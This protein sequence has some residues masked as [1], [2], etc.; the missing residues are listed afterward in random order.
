MK[1]GEQGSVRKRVGMGGQEPDD[2]FSV[3]ARSLDSTDTHF[4][5]RQGLHVSRSFIFSV[6]RGSAFPPYMPT[7]AK[8]CVCV[9]TLLRG[10]GETQGGN[11]ARLV[12]RG[13]FFVW[14][15]FL[16]WLGRIWSGRTFHVGSRRGKKKRRGRYRVL[17]YLHAVGATEDPRQHAKQVST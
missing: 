12:A 4:L 2:T 8:V 16:G 15:N 11:L 9:V 10:A 3:S 6:P 1:G 14:P 17:L 5:L 7:D 13:K